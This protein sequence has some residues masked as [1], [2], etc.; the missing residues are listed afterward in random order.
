MSEARTAKNTALDVSKLPTTL[1][2]A[3]SALWWGNALLLAI[4]TAMFGILIAIYFSVM[5]QTDPFPPPRVERLP[6]LYQS[7]PN[8]T[9][10]I[11]GLIVILVSMIPAV[12]LDKSARNRRVGMIKILLPI[13]LTLNIV[14]IIIRYYEFDSLLF[15]WEDNAYGS[16]TWMILGMHM[17]HLIVLACEDIFLLAWT[18]VKGVDD[19][20][21]LD[22][23]VL[24][25]YWYWVVGVWLVLFG[26]V[27]LV[28]RFTL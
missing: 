27:Y 19:K 7:Y 13:T 5:M 16:I 18:Y 24:G 22:I 28:P 1:F 10:P 8:L 21:I 14:A 15:K 11:I 3:H 9:L 25:V 6:V 12:M 4:E 17:F 20:H 26:I 23:T 2:D